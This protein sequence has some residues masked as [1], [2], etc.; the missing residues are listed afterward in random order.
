[1]ASLFFSYSHKDETL[2]DQL[3]VHLSALQRQGLIT[4]WH[5][6][7]IA[8]GDDFGVKIDEN[9]AAADVILL[10]VTPDFIASDYCYNKELALAMERHR[11]GTARVI[12]VIVRPCDW[13]GL[14]FGQLR[15]T[16]RDGLPVT[17]WPNIDEAFLD[18]VKDI[19]AALPGSPA[20]A[21]A[22]KNNDAPASAGA[23]FN[24]PVRSSNLRVSKEFT[25][26]DLDKFRHE[27]FDYAARFFEN[28]LREL[29]ERN[30]GI[31]VDF[32]R[33]DANT[34]TASAYRHGA[35]AC[36]C[37]VT[38]GGRGWGQQGIE[39]SESDAPRG[40]M[41]EAVY[42]KA[43]DQLLFFEPLGLGS[44]GNERAKLSMQGAAEMFW[45]LFI[46]PLQR[47]KHR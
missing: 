27:G 47:T 17:K 25:D 10:L 30:P 35:K 12:P 43:E 8:A 34:F 39:Y 37:T 19:K 21:T 33:I 14:P 32:R 26:R 4:A 11:A 44:H 36:Q 38:L 46:A 13:H 6:R 20:R 7:R 42:A 9:L 3:E 29:T 16:P 15:A 2:R 40:A 45:G 1:M 28:S 23:A 31:E 18:I 22:R 41:N 5:D 24:D